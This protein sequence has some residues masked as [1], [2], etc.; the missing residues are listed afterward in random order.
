MST[1]AVSV[2]EQPHLIAVR[3]GPSLLRISERLLLVLVCILG[4][5]YRTMLG[6][7]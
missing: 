4:C 7:S 2:D 1:H 3:A 6:E 5:V